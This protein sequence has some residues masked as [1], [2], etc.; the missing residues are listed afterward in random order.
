MR[1]KAEINFDG[2]E[3][4]RVHTNRLNMEE[5]LVVS[6]HFLICQIL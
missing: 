2:R 6:S 5:V 3:V 4:T 1:F